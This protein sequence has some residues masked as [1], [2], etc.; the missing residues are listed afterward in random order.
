MQCWKSND[1]FIV[2]GIAWGIVCSRRTVNLGLGEEGLT[3][4]ERAKGDGKA[5]DGENLPWGKLLM[6]KG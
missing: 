1:Q 5:W 4:P 6:R 3:L 2:W